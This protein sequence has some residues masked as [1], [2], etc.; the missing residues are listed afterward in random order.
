MQAEDADVVKLLKV[1]TFLPHEQIAALEAEVQSNPGARAAQKALARELTT[2]VHGAGACE[3]AMRASEIMFGGGLD[4]VSESVFK[5][6][7]G[8]VPTKEIEKVATRGSGLALTEAFVHAGLTTS[9]GQARKD[10]EGGGAYVNNAREADATRSLAADD[11]LFG[12]YILLR[13]G[14]RNYAVIAAV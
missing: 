10:I 9:K 3:D 7:V 5:D 8:E 6:V 11:L 12:R 14:K 13:K 1:L 2:L 4:G